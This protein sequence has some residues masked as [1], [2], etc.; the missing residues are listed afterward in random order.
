MQSEQIPNQPTPTPAAPPSPP[1]AQ[2]LTSRIPRQSDIMRELQAGGDN[3]LDFILK[4]TQ[5]SAVVP[6]PPVLPQFK[7]DSP[8]PAPA[9]AA[10]QPEV[11]PPKIDPMPSFGDEPKKEE[12][13]PAESEPDE[14]DQ[15]PEDPER[16][17]YIRLRTKA[18]EAVKT[19]KELT[20]KKAELE[21]EL[22]R[23]K[24]GEVVPEILQEKENKIAELSKY[25]KLY[26]LKSSEEYREKYVKPISANT[27]KLKQIFKDYGVD[28]SELDAAISHTLSLDNKAQLNA[29]LS[30]NFD[31]VGASE[32]K[33]IV[34]GMKA[35]QAE[36]KTLEAEPESMLTRLQ[37]ESEQIRQAEEAR[38]FSSI[39][40]TAKTSWVESLLDIRQEGKLTELIRKENDPA[41]NEKF[42][43]PI[44]THSA[45]EYG[46]LVTALAKG[47]L[48]EM[49][50]ELAK[51]L[52][53][54]VLR[55]TAQGIAFEA[56]DVALNRLE[57][58]ESSATRINQLL[59]PQVGGGVQS[60]SPPPQQPKELTPQAAAA[61]LVNSILLKK[62]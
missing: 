41:F 53:N 15:I 39:T 57:Q 5:Q 42:V 47:G 17:N 45:Q 31:S 3:P 24:T 26:N 54:M 21:A 35:L 29:F 49:P 51:G 43:D 38:R 19:A 61:E 58:I 60:S 27:E 40:E 11:Q 59:R 52:A 6:P 18:K 46:K 13:K 28:D 2:E 37:E 44:L 30:E 10:P 48:K 33:E 1:P 14:I 4:N 62:K 56:R 32:V 12:A 36:A 7:A 23:Y 16:E 34:Q 8:A 20:A 25:E 9:A 22:E 50:K 55:A